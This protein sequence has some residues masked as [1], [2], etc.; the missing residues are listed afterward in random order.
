[1]SLVFSLSISGHVT[2]DGLTM[3]KLI[4]VAKTAAKSIEATNESINLVIFDNETNDQ[5]TRMYAGERLDA[6]LAD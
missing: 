5:Q 3:D 6:L 4:E 2:P 1:M